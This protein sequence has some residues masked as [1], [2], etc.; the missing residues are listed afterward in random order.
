L[1]HNRFTSLFIFHL[2][3]LGGH[4]LGLLSDL[5]TCLLELV[6][7]VIYHFFEGEGLLGIA[8]TSKGVE[9]FWKLRLTDDRVLHLTDILISENNVGFV[10]TEFE[11]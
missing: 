3:N 6:I 9:D 11:W 5:V 2:A 4:F 8:V 7:L 10:N 1:K